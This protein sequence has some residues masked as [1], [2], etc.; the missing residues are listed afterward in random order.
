MRRDVSRRWVAL[1][2]P[3]APTRPGT[4]RTLASSPEESTRVSLGES[5]AVNMISAEITILWPG[6]CQVDK[7]IAIAEILIPFIHSVWYLR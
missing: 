3:D 2:S 4:R 7:E 6:W 5:K 1:P